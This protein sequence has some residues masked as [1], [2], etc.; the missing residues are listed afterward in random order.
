MKILL[1]ILTALILGLNCF[2]QTPRQ[3]IKADSTEIERKIEIKAQK[4]KQS[5]SENE[6][7][8]DKL[9]I[10]F[11][12]DTFRI[13]ERERLKLEIDY[14]T[15]GMVIAALD[16]NKEYDE[17]LN[18]YYKRLIN[19]LNEADREILKKSQRSWI[20]FRDS[21]KELNSVLMSDYFSG[22]GTIQ[23]VIAA[24]RV[25]DLTRDRVIELYRY[26]GRKLE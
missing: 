21:E 15:N 25:L 23:R 26:L 6:L 20:K 19:S 9:L 18:K 1:I 11:R 13:E 7:T 22:N 2:G 14:S 5:L 3:V 24:S 17:L 8:T 16:A 10:E 12:V 4:I